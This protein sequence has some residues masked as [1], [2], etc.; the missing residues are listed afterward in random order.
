MRVF[1]A[2]SGLF[3]GVPRPDA[4]RLALTAGALGLACAT[5][6]TFARRYPFEAPRELLFET[7][8]RVLQERGEDLAKTDRSRWLVVTSPKDWHIDE[9]Q[10]L[11]YRLTAAFNEQTPVRTELVIYAQGDKRIPR[12]GKIYMVDDRDPHLQG[13][14][15]EIFSATAVRLSSGR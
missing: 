9:D 15:G 13:V 6:Q 14:I 2:I 12:K 3:A 11:H 7:V 8:I 10:V 5:P 1:R 4:L